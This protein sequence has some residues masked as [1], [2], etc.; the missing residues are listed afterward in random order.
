[1]IRHLAGIAEIVDD[2]EA[3][4]TFYRDDLGLEVDDSA[5][6]D[7]TYGKRTAVDR[8]NPGFTIECEVDDVP[9]ASQTLESRG[10]QL[11][12]G[13]KAEPWG[14][15]TARLSLPSGAISGSA[16]TPWARQIDE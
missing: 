7:A 10:I 3:A 12:H 16:E 15:T 11:L 4:V 14:Q 1:M 6:A 8:V 9:S 5:A 2:L 13:P